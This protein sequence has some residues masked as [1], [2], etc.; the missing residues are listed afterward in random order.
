MDY[1]DN[2]GK[3]IGSLTSSVSNDEVVTINRL[4]DI[5]TITVRDRNTGKVTTKTFFGYSPFGK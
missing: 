1:I 5:T 2:S 4:R 3:K